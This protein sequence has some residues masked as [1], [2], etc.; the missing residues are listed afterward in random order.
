MSTDFTPY[1]EIDIRKLTVNAER[2][3][4]IIIAYRGEK[5]L[6]AESAALIQGIVVATGANTTVAAVEKARI[7]DYQARS[8]IWSECV[9]AGRPECKAN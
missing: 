9:A 7:D 6:D 2:V 4:Q 1:K 5:T 8:A 3:G